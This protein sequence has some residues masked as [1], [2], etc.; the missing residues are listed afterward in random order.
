MKSAHIYGCLIFLNL[1]ILANTIGLLYYQSQHHNETTPTIELAPLVNGS[2]VIPLSEPKNSQKLENAVP[3]KPAVVEIGLYAKGNEA[4]GVFT[5]FKDRSALV[6]LASNSEWTEV[7][8]RRGFPVWVRSDLVTEIKNGYVQVVVNRA[9]ARTKPG[10]DNSASVGKLS[11]GDVLR[12]SRKQGE[13]IRVWS[14]LK[15]RAWVKTSELRQSP[16][17][18]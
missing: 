17:N 2:K 9:N 4:L 5:A 14:P 7:I 8:S 10:T 12:V 3:I 15:F 18:T 13:W 16:R 6:A 11:A 1:F